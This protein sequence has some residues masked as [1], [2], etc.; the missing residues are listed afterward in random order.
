MTAASQVVPRVFVTSDTS[1]QVAIPGR[2]L[3]LSRCHRNLGRGWTPFRAS[4][5]VL[6][7]FRASFFVFGD[8]LGDV[9]PPG[10]SFGDAPLPGAVPLPHE[11]TEMA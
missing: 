10:G 1:N 4:F 5:F 3:Y 2:N 9:L 6:A 11:A 8:W 7:P